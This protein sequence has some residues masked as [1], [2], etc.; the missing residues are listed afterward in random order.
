MTIVSL[1]IEYLPTSPLVATLKY[2]SSTNIIS[3]SMGKK[4]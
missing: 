1:Y 2:L 4:A 3:I